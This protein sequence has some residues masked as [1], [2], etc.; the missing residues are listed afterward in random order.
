M[1]TARHTHLNS[2]RTDREARLQI[3]YTGF[4]AAFV[5]PKEEA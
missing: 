3:L 1:T 2:R 4:K 5:P